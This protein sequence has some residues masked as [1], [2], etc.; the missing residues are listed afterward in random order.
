MNDRLSVRSDRDNRLL[1]QRRFTRV[2]ILGTRWE[3]CVGERVTYVVKRCNIVHVSL[4]CYI[5]F[6]VGYQLKQLRCG[7]GVESVT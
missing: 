5:H 3:S 7:D 6:H 2:Q 4:Y 1:F